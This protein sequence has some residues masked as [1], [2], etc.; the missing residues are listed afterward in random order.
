[1]PRDISGDAMR[2]HFL[3]SLYSRDRLIRW[4]AAHPAWVLG[5]QD[6]TWWSR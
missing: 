6:E 2:R 5:F 3:L 4:A 1:M